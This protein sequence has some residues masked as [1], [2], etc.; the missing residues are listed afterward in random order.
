MNIKAA[1]ILSLITV[2]FITACS[3]IWPD[4]PELPP[5]KFAYSAWVG[6]YPIAIAKEKGFFT[7]Q[8]VNVQTIYLGADEPQ[9][10]NLVAGKYDGMTTTLG[11]VISAGTDNS[12][13]RIVLKIDQSAG[14]DVIIAQSQIKSVADLKSKTIGVDLGK[15]GELF[16]TKMLE[17]NG[18]TTEQVTLI[19]AN[20]EQ[21]LNRLKS[22][23]IQAGHTWEPFASQAV[24][25]G[26]R[27]IFTSAQTPG[28]I[29]D[30]IT[31]RETVLKTRPAD[32]RAFI[33]AWFQA[34]DYW[35]NHLKEGNMIIGKVLKI[36]ADTISLEGVKLLTLEDNKLGFIPANSTDSLYYTAQL[37]TNFYIRTGGLTRPPDIKKLLEPSFLD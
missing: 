16:V 30:V 21:V 11:N 24:K 4:K 32:I 7:Q 25:A 10:A 35:K 19:K 36:P 6:Y 12:N 34:V 29:S 28:L 31:F 27:V 9:L 23:E 20:E 8:G 18:L 2:L 37:Y 26:F 1:L 3:L 17:S 14:A 15:F 13:L 33:R 5:L 22:N